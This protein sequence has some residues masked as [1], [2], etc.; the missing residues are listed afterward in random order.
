MQIEQLEEVPESIPASEDLLKPV[1]LPKCDLSLV[2]EIVRVE[3]DAVGD[4]NLI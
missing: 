4:C 1:Y 2:R 3:I